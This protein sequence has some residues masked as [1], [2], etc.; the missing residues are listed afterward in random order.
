MLYCKDNASEWK[1][2]LLSI[3]RAQLILCKDRQ[4]RRYS[5][6]MLSK[7][8]PLAVGCAKGGKRRCKRWP[9]GLRKATFGRLKDGLSELKGKRIGMLIKAFVNACYGKRLKEYSAA[10][11]SVFISKRTDKIFCLPAR[12][13]VCSPQPT[14][15]LVTGLLVCLKNSLRLGPV[16][17]KQP[18]GGAREGGVEPV[19]VVGS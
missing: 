19:N 11:L 4:Y 8:K 16:D 14:G 12:L 10:M 3:S 5:Q 1:E 9:F 2:S 7:I 18:L 6:T 15:L 13:P 17:E